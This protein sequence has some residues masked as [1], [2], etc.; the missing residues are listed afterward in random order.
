MSGS[1]ITC[2]YVGKT[3]SERNVTTNRKTMNNFWSIEEFRS[4][5][6]DLI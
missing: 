4:Q 1:A 5:G 2:I 6:F 3:G